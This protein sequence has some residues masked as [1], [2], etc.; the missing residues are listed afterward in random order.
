M[1]LRCS[2][3]QQGGPGRAAVGTRP[4]R[5]PQADLLAALQSG[6]VAGAAVDVFESEPPAEHEWALIEHP[7]LVAT[8]HLGAYTL[9]AQGCE[10]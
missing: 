2:R 10:L 7:K 1:Q 5:V 9:E 8:P 3:H 6:H 4:R